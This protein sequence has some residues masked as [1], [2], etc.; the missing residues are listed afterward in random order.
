MVVIAEGAPVLG[1]AAMANT[2]WVADLVVLR[3]G[4]VKTVAD[5]K[6]RLI[7]VSGAKSLTEWL[8]QE[9]SRQQ[10]WDARA[11]APSGSAPWRRR[12]RR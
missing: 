8:A 2:P 6:G 1:V 5:L 7:S 11:S 12:R 4:P 9:L 10:G 3:D